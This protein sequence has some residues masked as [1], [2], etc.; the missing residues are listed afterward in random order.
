SKSPMATAL[1]GKLLTLQGEKLVAFDPGTRP[2]PEMYLV[3]FGASWNGGTR[4]FV[5]GLTARY[6][7]ARRNGND[8]FELLYHS[9]DRS[10]QEHKAFV[11]ATVMPWPSVKY[12]SVGG[13]K[14]LERWAMRT[15]PSLIVLNANGDVILDSEARDAMGHLFTPTQIWEQ[16]S[17]M[18]SVMTGATSSAKRGMHRLATLQHVR[19]HPTGEQ[20]PRPYVLSLDRDRY[21][22][23]DPKQFVATLGLDDK[24]HVISATFDPALGA[25]VEDQLTQDVLKWLFL[26]AV[27]EGKPQPFTVKVP[28]NF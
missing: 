17:E 2:E 10:E 8:A 26:P 28:I 12:G 13:L 27:R 11:S 19:A 3:F 21:Q 1:R 24:G 7:E 14:L 18:L 16:F 6:R 5:P 22:T 15:V 25:V 23:I 4:N 20:A 9:R